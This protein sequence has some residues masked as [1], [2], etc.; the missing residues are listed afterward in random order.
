MVVIGSTKDFVATLKCEQASASSTPKA[1]RQDF[2]S[3]SSRDSRK[4]QILSG[5]S[6]GHRTC[7]SRF[8]DR[9]EY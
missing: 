3:R 4:T 9:C 1:K 5:R 6:L 7:V 2:W 8:S